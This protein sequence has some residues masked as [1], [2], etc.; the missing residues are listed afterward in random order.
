MILWLLFASFVFGGTVL[1]LDKPSIP[2][3]QIKQA[4]RVVAFVLWIIV[5][6]VVYKA[7]LWHTELVFLIRGC[8]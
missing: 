1:L 7:I 6:G 8:R 4:Y 5:M 2:A 3:W